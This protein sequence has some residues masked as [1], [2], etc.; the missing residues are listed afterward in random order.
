MGG[1]AG[2]REG[3]PT[4]ERKTVRSGGARDEQSECKPDAK[5]ERDS[6]KHQVRAQ[7]SR[8][9]PVPLCRRADPE[10]GG[11]YPQSRAD[12]R[13]TSRRPLP[14]RGHRFEEE[15]A[16]RARRPNLRRAD[17]RAETPLAH[18]KNHRRLVQHRAR[19]GWPRSSA[20]RSPHSRYCVIRDSGTG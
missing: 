6:A 5:R 18:S 1:M 2:D 20:S 19:P 9:D 15:S 12:L 7:P 16:N 14:Y 11:C 17:G 10:I 13:R 8:L 3:S 4:E